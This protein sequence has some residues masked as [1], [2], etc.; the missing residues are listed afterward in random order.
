MPWGFGRHLVYTPAQRSVLIGLLTLLIGYL[1]VRTAMHR[2]FVSDP[3][4]VEGD[5]AAS[6]ADKLDP[7]TADWTELAALPGMGEK[8]A[9]A[10]VARRELVRSRDPKAVAFR[11]PRDLFY[12]EGFGPAMV[13]QLK[14]Y[15]LFPATTA[16]TNP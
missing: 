12:V 8:R 7:N 3:P 14:P 9:R 11:T 6:L 15:L 10:L 2:T 16:S 13:E 4:A 1:T 5:R